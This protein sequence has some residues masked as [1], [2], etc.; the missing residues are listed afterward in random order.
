MNSN[1][2]EGGT[3]NKQRIDDRHSTV[4]YV[5]SKYS[6]KMHTSTPVTHSSLD[7]YYDIM[8]YEI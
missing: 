2:E 3:W 7:T 1:L 6:S 5:V 8:L 4:L